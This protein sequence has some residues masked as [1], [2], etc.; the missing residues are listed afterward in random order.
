MAKRVT[1]KVSVGKRK[2][3][4]T[5]VNQDSGCTR[6]AETGL[7]FI[8]KHKANRME[9]STSK[10]NKV[11]YV[12][13]GTSN[14]ML[15]H[16]EWFS[17]LEKSEQTRV[18]E[19]GDDTPHPIEHIK[20]VPLSHVGQKGIMRNVLHIPKITKNIVS[21]KQIDDQGMQ[22]R[23]TQCVCFIQEEGRIIAQGR[24]DR[25]MF[26]LKTNEV[27]TV[28]FAKRHKVESDIDLWHKL[29]SHINFPKIQEM[30]SKQIIFCLQKF[31]SRKGQLCEAC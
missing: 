27:G 20:D 15:N 14:H 11:W 17:T 26:I 31:S 29:F 19:T 7:A 22:R 8:M 4:R 6:Q 2:L 3:I 1:R 21:I 9:M 23:F 24:R 16:N 28:M 10:P 25:R 30:Q 5:K 12:D 13:S 18:F